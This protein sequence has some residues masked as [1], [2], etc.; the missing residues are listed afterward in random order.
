MKMKEKMKEDMDAL[1]TG[2]NLSEEFVSK[3]TTIFEAAV[4]ARAEEVI[5]EAEAELVEQFEA[6]VVE[7]KSTRRVSC[8]PNANGMAIFTIIWDT[9]SIGTTVLDSRELRVG[10]ISPIA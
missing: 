6:A 7:E 3:A 8:Y 9:G 4:I 2:E 5:A 1:F 10:I